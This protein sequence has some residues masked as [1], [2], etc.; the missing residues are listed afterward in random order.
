M[1]NKPNGDYVAIAH[2]KHHRTPNLSKSCT[3]HALIFVGTRKNAARIVPDLETVLSSRRSRITRLSETERHLALLSD[4]YGDQVGRHYV[5]YIDEP[6]YVE[7]LTVA[8]ASKSLYNAYSR[9]MKGKEEKPPK[10]EFSH[11]RDCY[12]KSSSDFNVI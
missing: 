9:W 10:F 12:V 4:S 3:R 7:R 5:K 8:R 2:M 6:A 1:K 11:G